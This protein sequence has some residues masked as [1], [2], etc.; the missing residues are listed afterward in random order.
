MRLTI[1]TKSL[2]DI[3]I[4]RHAMG[5]HKK[6][7]HFFLFDNGTFFLVNFF[8]TGFNFNFNQNTRDSSYILKVPQQ[9]DLLMLS[10]VTFLLH[11]L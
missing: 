5:K 3:D 6:E 7:N 2:R 10:L 11:V 9:Q 4:T 8:R 1:P